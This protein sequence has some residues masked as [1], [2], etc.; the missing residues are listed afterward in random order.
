MPDGHLLFDGDCG[1]CTRL[2]AWLGR[3]GLGCGI[4]PIRPAR[5][6]ELGVDPDRATREIPFVL[7]SGEIRYGAR[8]IAAALATGPA[9]L[10]AAGA[11]IDA[12]PLRPAAAWVYG[13]VARNRGR[14]PGGTAACELPAGVGG[15]SADLTGQ[16][17]TTPTPSAA[18]AHTV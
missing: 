2:A 12:R 14:L 4:E 11:V 8:G 15:R 3:R 16:V 1:I 17:P 13:L 10:R 6:A 5:L 9:W 18:S 7:P